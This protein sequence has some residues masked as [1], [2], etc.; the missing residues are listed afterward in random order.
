V[1]RLW[2]ARFKLEE[3]GQRLWVGTVEIEH[4][5]SVADLLTI[6]R[7]IADYTEALQILE[8]TIS[9]KVEGRLVQRS[10]QETGK[11]SGWDGRVL[12]A[13]DHFDDIRN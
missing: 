10:E 11:V 3:T 7:G 9:P 4:P 12:L 13:G 6:P 1:L 8:R 2:P 5:V